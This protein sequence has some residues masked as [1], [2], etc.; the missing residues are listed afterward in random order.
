MLGSKG[1]FERTILSPVFAFKTTGLVSFKDFTTMRTC[2]RWMRANCS[3]NLPWMEFSQGKQ[4]AWIVFIWLRRLYCHPFGPSA[5]TSENKSQRGQTCGGARLCIAGL[6]SG[7][8]DLRN[9]AE[10]P[11]GKPF[12]RRAPPTELSRLHYA[13]FAARR[14]L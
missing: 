5:G 1:S 2:K 12:R 14:R 13:A 3:G 10:P 11:T 4:R 9:P 6:D 8:C 7:L